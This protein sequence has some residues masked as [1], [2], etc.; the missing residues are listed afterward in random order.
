MAISIERLIN[1]PA[2]IKVAAF[3]AQTTP[4]RLGYSIAKSA[5]WWISSRRNSELGRAVRSNQWVATGE[6]SSSHLLDQAVQTV[7]RNSARSIYDLYHYFNDA[8][9]VGQMYSIEPSFQTVYNRPEFD[10]C[11][12]VVAGLHMVGFDLGLQWLC[13]NQFKPLVLT[14]PNP[15]GS[16]RMEFETR[17]KTGM[18]LVPG[19]FTGLR[20]AIRHLQQGGVVVTGIDRPVPESEPR[21]CFFGRPAALPIH[22]IYLALKAHVPI[23][24]AATRL[25]ENGKYHIHASPPIEMDS[26]PNRADERL[27]N[28]E[29]VLAV[30][31]EFIRPAPQQWLIFQPVWPE[32][33]NDI[34]G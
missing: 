31:E 34:P 19:S 1:N 10:R 18:N 7:F 21:P 22:H 17:Q 32:I 29:K 9:M 13:R 3:I 33:I 20:Q 12:L 23:V 8:G 5:A 30:A 25:E 2:A 28:A 15:Q 16:R 24:V 4:S 26:Y 11:G 6:K 14:I 27:M